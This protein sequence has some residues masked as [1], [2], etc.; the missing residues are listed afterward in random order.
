MIVNYFSVVL[1]CSSSPSPSLRWQSPGILTICILPLS[2]TDRP[3]TTTTGYSAWDRSSSRPSKTRTWRTGDAP[4]ASSSPGWVCRAQQA[5]EAWLTPAAPG[6]VGSRPKGKQNALRPHFCPC[7]DPRFCS[8]DVYFTS[9][10]P[11]PS[12]MCAESII[13]SVVRPL[14][15]WVTAWI[16]I[17][18]SIYWSE[19]FKENQKKIH[20]NDK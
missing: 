15:L 14:T 8:I 19:V 17:K 10:L 12:V 5:W 20:T 11:Q 13:C 2:A 7:C 16:S 3:P 4:T 18:G 1:H 9:K 6:W